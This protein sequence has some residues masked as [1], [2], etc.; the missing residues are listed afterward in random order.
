M[1][2]EAFPRLEQAG[3]VLPRAHDAEAAR[4][5][6]DTLLGPAGRAVLERHGFLPAT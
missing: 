1:P 6:R 3:L 2:S 5:V 4:A